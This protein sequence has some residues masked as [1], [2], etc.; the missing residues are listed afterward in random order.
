MTTTLPGLR[1]DSIKDYGMLCAIQGL[2]NNMASF[3]AS[4]SPEA[5]PKAFKI[6]RNLRA[7]TLCGSILSL[8]RLF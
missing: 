1:Q 7:A 2:T 6:F 4:Y 8:M 5:E 3:H